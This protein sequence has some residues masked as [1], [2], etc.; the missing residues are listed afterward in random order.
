[1]LY[2]GDLPFFRP[3]DVAVEGENVY[4]SDS[5]TNTVQV[6]SVFGQYVRS[7]SRYGEGAQPFGNLLGLALD[8]QGRV[9]AVDASAGSIGTLVQSGATEEIHYLQKLQGPGQTGLIDAVV[10]GAGRILAVDNFNNR[11]VVIS[12]GRI[13]Q[14]I[15][16]G[17]VEAGKFSAPTFCTLDSEGMLY[18]S[19]ALNGRVQVFDGKGVFQRHFGRYEQGLGGL[20]RPKGVALSTRGEVFVADS[21]QN[22]IQVFDRK[23]KFLAVLTDES[24]EPLDLG[25]PN[26][27]AIDGENR[28]YIAERLSRRLQIREI[29]Y[30]N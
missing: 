24:G 14:T 13:E 26:G 29:I 11:I 3:A 23:G 21:W 27:L 30:E 15:G 16:E 4:L 28:I 9:F 10:D 2:G 5:G 22:V 20:G 25:S 7:Y 6:F 19:D 1:V 18:V 17:G 8:G 12:G